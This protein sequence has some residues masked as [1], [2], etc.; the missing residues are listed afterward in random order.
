MFQPLEQEFY[1]ELVN[2]TM[3]FPRFLEDA[4]KFMY[5]VQFKK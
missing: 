5:K 3:M 4:Y 2:K 1:R